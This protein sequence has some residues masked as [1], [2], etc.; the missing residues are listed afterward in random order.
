MATTK[1]TGPLI[2]AALVDAQKSIGT[3]RKTDKNTAQGG[4][5]MFRGVDAVVNAASPAFHEHGIV[6]T[7]EVLDY[8]HKQ[9][10]VGK[11]RTLME[12]VLVRVRY[13]FRHIEDG[14][15][16]SATVIGAAGDSG[17]KATPKA[18]SVALRTALLQTLMLPTDEPDPDSYTYGHDDQRTGYRDDAPQVE[19]P[20]EELIRNLMRCAPDGETR[21]ANWVQE[22]ARS[23]GLDLYSRPDMERLLTELSDATAAQAVQEQLG[24]Q[25]VE[26]EAR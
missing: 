2:L 15:E 10:E 17:D 24:G 26:E 7:P 6:V 12:H 3:V 19:Q 8:H 4:G 22:Q 11:G 21:P 25:P 23:R 9:L 5:Y 16:V 18:M 13:T 1:T 14:S 20:S